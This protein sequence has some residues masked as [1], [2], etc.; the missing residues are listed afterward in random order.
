MILKVTLIFLEAI[1]WASELRVMN[2]NSYM[3]L[4]TS[5]RW[6]MSIYWFLTLWSIMFTTR[7]CLFRG[8]GVRIR[9]CCRCPGCPTLVVYLV[10]CEW[11]RM[12]CG[13]LDLVC[14]CLY[15]CFVGL[16]VCVLCG[17]PCALCMSV[18]HALWVSM[19]RVLCVVLRALW[20]V[21]NKIPPTIYRVPKS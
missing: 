1:S 6:E 8:D 9:G 19:L 13:C 4:V 3:L 5:S 10:L 7:I 21:L 11:L 16:C 20:L 2:E 15:A 17:C 12:L 14:G 18:C